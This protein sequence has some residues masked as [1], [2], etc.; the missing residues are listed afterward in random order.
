MDVCKAILHYFLRLLAV[1]L[2]RYVIMLV[3]FVGTKQTFPP[4]QTLSLF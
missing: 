1:P 4:P 2:C 3:S